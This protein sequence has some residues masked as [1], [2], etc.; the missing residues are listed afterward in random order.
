MDTTFVEDSAKPPT[1]KTTPPARLAIGLG[2]PRLGV[3]RSGVATTPARNTADIQSFFDRCSSQYAEQ[4]GDADQLLEYRL[5]LIR[6][7]SGLRESD[8]V[9]DV[10]CG[11]GHHLLAL[12]P[13]LA[14][15]IGVDVSPGMIG[16]A[17]ARQTGSLWQ[18][19]VRFS[20]DDGE[21]LASIVPA[22]IDLALC[23]GALEH[24]L[25]KPAVLA[26]IRRVLAPGGR[27]FCLTPDGAHPWYRA[28]APLLGFSTKHLSTDRF[29]TRAELSALLE[30][31]GFAHARFGSWSFIPKGDMPPAL[32]AFLGGLDA[33]GRVARLDSLRGG[34][35]VC[36]Y[37]K[38]DPPG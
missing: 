33:V 14:Q 35:W 8:V 29:L 6:A 1:M 26:S 12:A 31:A 24:M 25:D 36:A 16:V 22:S 17:R 13:G 4:H 3:A 9:L 5:G 11:N 30:E 27:L 2:V 10:G 32:G 19:R 23:I 38:D 34:L 15:G 21:S 7:H 18:H 37:A 20:V 28:I